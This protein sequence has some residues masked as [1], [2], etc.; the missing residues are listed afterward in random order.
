MDKY[1]S[2]LLLFPP[3]VTYAIE[4]RTEFNYYIENGVPIKVRINTRPISDVKCA[5]EISDG[6]WGEISVSDL[7]A[8]INYHRFSHRRSQKWGI[9]PKFL[10]ANLM[11]KLPTSSQEKLMLEFLQQN[12]T[13]DIVEQRAEQLLN[14]LE[15][16]YPLRLKQFLYDGKT[17][18]LFVRGKLCDWVLI[19]NGDRSAIQKVSTY[20]YLDGGHVRFIPRNPM[21]YKNGALIG[22]ICIDNIHR[23][24]SRGDQFA[25][26]AMALLND[27]TTIEMVSTIKEY[28][29]NEILNKEIE[30]RVGD[31][32]EV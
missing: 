19:D 30:C 5:L 22:P 3:N 8:F 10:W 15:I 13:Q 31:I 18:S 1:I 28:I 17:K 26:R 9:S 24:S 25:A 23:N 20:I 29:P 4:N 16:E 11:G 21:P 14:E 12:R 2:R 6:I 32:N 7:N 27:E